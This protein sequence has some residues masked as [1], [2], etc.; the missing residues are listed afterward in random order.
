MANELILNHKPEL[1]DNVKNCLASVRWNP[2]ETYAHDVD[3]TMVS[4]LGEEQKKIR[5]CPED[6]TE[7][8]YFKGDLPKQHAITR[9]KMLVKTRDD[10]FLHITSDILSRAETSL[11]GNNRGLTRITC[12]LSLQT[13]VEFLYTRKNFFKL[14]ACRLC[15][16]Q[17]LKKC[18]LARAKIIE[19]LTPR[20]RKV[21]YGKIKTSK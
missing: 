19:N 9:F 15:Q 16:P 1:L 10:V 8:Y 6:V 18:Q 17:E 7:V 12:S 11:V 2:V 5:V 14:F 20:I 21:F 4:C 13:L 3:V